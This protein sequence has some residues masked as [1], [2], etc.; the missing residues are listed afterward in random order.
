MTKLK[1]E[2]FDNP[3]VYCFDMDQ[4]NLDSKHLICTIF[5]KFRGQLYFADVKVWLAYYFEWK[6]WK[7]V[8]S[9]NLSDIKYDGLVKIISHLRE[10]GK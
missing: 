6:D 10:Q 3:E 9:K 5:V 4:Y 2:D 8:L 1:N 7:W